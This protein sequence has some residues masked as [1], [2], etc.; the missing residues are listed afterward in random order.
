MT[1]LVEKIVSVTKTATAIKARIANV[2]INAIAETIANVMKIAPVKA[3]TA[4]R[5]KKSA[6]TSITNMKRKMGLNI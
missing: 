4:K 5:M 6:T 1:A 2:V 3:D